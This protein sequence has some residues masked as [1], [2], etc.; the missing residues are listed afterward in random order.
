VGALL[1]TQFEITIP[2][3]VDI[4]VSVAGRTWLDALE[5]AFRALGEDGIPPDA[6]CDLQRDGTVKVEDPAGGR[7]M[8]VR[9]VGVNLTDLA[10]P[11]PDAAPPAG[12]RL[13]RRPDDA[14]DDDAERKPTPTILEVPSVDGSRGTRRFLD[15]GEAP[16][17][18]LPRPQ[19]RAD[20]S[21]KPVRSSWGDAS[22]PPADGG[23]RA[24][25]HDKHFKWGDTDH[26]KR[27]VNRRMELPALSPLNDPNLAPREAYELMLRLADEAFPARAA[28]SSSRP[29][30]APRSTGA[31]IRRRWPVRRPARRPAPRADGS[32][33]ATWAPT[34]P[35]STSGP[36]SG[37]RSWR[38]TTGG[39]PS[40]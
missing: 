9:P 31:R 22:K 26:R 33:I 25:R 24:G 2:G 1:S 17:S 36:C 29:G 37:S 16:R 32:S 8:T 13:V 21:L 28:L 7:R 10:A 3:A 5:M 6:V 14:E 15:A 34:P 35:S 19:I 20:A 23:A 27:L 30:S 38:A 11:D 4:R 12:P 39:W 40:S 18:T